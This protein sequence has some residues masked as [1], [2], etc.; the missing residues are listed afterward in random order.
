MF[1]YV[2]KREDVKKNIY[3]YKCI[4]NVISYVSHKWLDHFLYSKLSHKDRIIL[5]KLIR[6]KLHF[7]I[8]EAGT[9]ELLKD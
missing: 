4:I 8:K 5:F 3:F 2:A 1:I 9:N 7:D 6:I